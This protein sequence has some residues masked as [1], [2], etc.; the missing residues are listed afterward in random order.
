MK[1]N[2]LVLWMKNVGRSFK[3][4]R[5]PT[6]SQPRSIRR[7]LSLEEL[8]ARDVPST[9]PVPFTITIPPGDATS[10]VPIYVTMYAQLL[11]QYTVPGPG[12]ATLQPLSWVSLTSGDV[13]NATANGTVEAFTEATGATTDESFTLPGAQV[14]AA[15]IIFSV[16]A[17]AAATVTGGGGASVT[18]PLPNSNNG[19]VYDFVEFTL[20]NNTA[21]TPALT[22]TINTSMIDQFG[23]PI[24]LNMMPT[25]PL[26]PAGVGVNIMTLSRNTVLTDYANYVAGTPFAE[27]EQNAFGAPITTG[28]LSPKD[29]PLVNTVQG[30]TVQVASTAAI[31]NAT[32]SG[33]TVTITANN[34]FAR[35]QT[36][37]VAGISPATYNGGFPILM[38]NSTSFTYTDTAGGL[39]TPATS[40][41]GATATVY[42]SYQ[43]GATPTYY[44]AVAGDQTNNGVSTTLASQLLPTS[45]TMT[46]ASSTTGFPAATTANP[47]SYFL[48]QV[49]DEILQVTDDSTTTWKIVHNQ[50]NTFGGAPLASTPVYL[51]V[52]TATAA[53]MSASQMSITVA[54]NTGFPTASL[55]NPFLI[56]VDAEIMLVTNDSSTTWNVVRGQDGSTAAT[57]LSG[58]F[59]TLFDQSKIGNTVTSVSTDPATNATLLQWTALP[60]ATNYNIYRGTATASGTPTVWYEFSS[61]LTS[62]TDNGSTTGAVLVPAAQVPFDPLDD[63]FSNQIASLFNTSL[64]LTAT[65]GTSDGVTYTLSGVPKNLSTI[66]PPPAGAQPPSGVQPNDMGLQFEV[67]NESPS[68]G[69]QVPVNTLF[70]VY[71]PAFNT[72][73]YVASNPSPPTYLVSGSQGNM[74]TMTGSGMVFAAAGVFADNVSQPIPG[75]V[76]NTAAYQTILGGIENEMV[77]AVTR[78]VQNSL[79]PANWANAPSQVAPTVSST[80]GSFGTTGFAPAGTYYYEITG[81]I[82]AGETTASLPF[83]AT[84]AADGSVTLNFKPNGQYTS[85]NIYRSPT[86]GGAFNFVESVPNTGGNVATALDTGILSSPGVSPPV[87]YPSTAPGPVSPPVQTAPTLSATGGRFGATGFAP[88]GTYFYVITAVNA[89]GQASTASNEETATVAANGSVALNWAADANAASFNVYRGSTT[90]HENTFLTNVPNTGGTVVSFVDAGSL[91]AAGPTPPNPSLAEPS[92]LYAQFFHQP[93]I[94][95]QGLAYASPYDDQGGQSST[96]SNSATPTSPLSFS[97]TLGNLTNQQ[98]QAPA[99]TSANSVGYMVGIGGTF[100]VTAT[101]VPT[102]SLAETATLPNGVTFTDNDNNTGT[103]VVSNTAAIGTYHLIFTANNG[104]GSPASQTF[105]LMINPLVVSTSAINDPTTGVNDFILFNNGTVYQQV[106]GS[107]TLTQ[108]TSAKTDAIAAGTD[109]TGHADV[110]VEFDSDKSLWTHTGTNQ[111]TGWTKLNSASA[112]TGLTPRSFV[113]GL[114][115]IVDVVFT[116]NQLWQ[117]NLAS[118]SKPT[119]ITSNV[120]FAAIG[121]HGT[122]ASAVPADFVAFQNSG[123]TNGGVWEHFVTSGTA[124]WVDV[125]SLDAYSI[126]ASLDLSDT[127]DLLVSSRNATGIVDHSVWGFRGTANSLTEITSLPCTSLSINASGNDFYVLQSDGSLYE[128]LENNPITTITVLVSAPPTAVTAVIAPNANTSV[129]F[130]QFVDGTLWEVS[131]LPSDLTYTS[132]AV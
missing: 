107:S 64:V 53:S 76:T 56:Q 63:Y 31:T 67:T 87:Y 123:T 80:G 79:L 94:S 69:G 96:L 34:S 23:L 126:S 127:A 77:A 75:G 55:A 98:M 41:A 38:A 5:K 89:Q 33:T 95:M 52:S 109:T 73:T 18:Q 101:A 74:S 121:V 7:R 40:V 49:A 108:V 39:T 60:G 113:A 130:F 42:N 116:N 6:A 58:A 43:Q 51:Y 68:T 88:A 97:L 12:G 104:V 119:M 100:T 2:G 131:G 20:K 54:S 62:F 72:N 66:A 24:A 9:S 105:T 17:P 36:V 110:T 19:N 30:V 48:V 37:T 32:S 124:H 10:A 71:N 112:L 114:D 13:Y 1:L 86:I 11:E 46:V 61:S 106:A 117:I 29:I 57:H 120:N 47:S 3:A 93:T 129:I 83:A 28:I 103:L 99:I 14:Q 45:S 91:G 8:E 22:L 84:V 132:V 102:A 118:V 90:G 70:Y 35:G 50:R 125:T 115:G 27:G 92:D 65:D 78:G 59:V 44:Y 128:H 85:F 81:V 21:P 25:D 111:T 16:G 15:H 26:S 82:S 4:T 122:G